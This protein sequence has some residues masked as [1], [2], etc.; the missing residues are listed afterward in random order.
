MKIL[1]ISQ[2]QKNFTKILNESTLIIDNKKK[3][4]KAVIIPYKEYLRLISQCQNK[5]D[6]LSM[7]SSGK[8]SKFKGIL[9]KNFKTRDEKYNS[10]VKD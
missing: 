2:A 9:D 7:L 4:K 8:F 3:E 10:I 5:E 1:N 6:L